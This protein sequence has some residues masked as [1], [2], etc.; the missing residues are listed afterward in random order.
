MLAFNTF[1]ISAGIGFVSEKR[2]ERRLTTILAADI[3]GYSRLMSSDEAGTLSKLKTH[4]KELLA[5][6]TTEYNGRVVKL[7]GD[8][9]LMEF[10]SVV[11]AINFAEDVQRSMK[12]RNE[13]VPEDHRIIYRIGV[14]IGDVIAEGDDLYGDG[15]NVASRL[16]ALAEPGGIC[17]SGNVFEH[18]KGKV[19][20]GFE[21]TGAQLVKNIPEP[22]Q[23]YR[24]MLESATAEVNASS[25]KAK[26]SLL[27]PA[28]A[29]SLLLLAV[30]VA[31][32]FSQSLREDPPSE[33]TT[34]TAVSDKPSIAVLPFNNL[35]DDQNQE[36]FVDGMTEDLITDLAKINNLFVIARNTSFTYKDKPVVV[37]EVA[38]ELGVKFV[39]EGSVRRIGDQVRINA[40]LIDGASG[41]HIWADR[42]DGNLA[43]VFALQDEVTGNIVEQLQ[44]TISPDE[45]SRRTKGDT[46]ST[47]AHD[48][49]LRGWQ[50]FRR[51]T[52]EDFVKAIPH[53]ERSVELDPSY[54]Q[55]WAALAALYWIA[56]RN[57]YAWSIIVNPDK[58]NG[59]SWYGALNKAE[60]NLRQAM[61][62]PTPLAHQIE[63]QISLEYRQYEQA[64]REAERAVGLNENDPAGHLAMAWAQIFSGQ[65]ESAITST[66]FG[67]QLDPQFPGSHLYA[68]GV[69][70]LILKRYEEAANT[71][72]RALSFNPENRAVLMPLSVAYTHLGRKEEAKVAL[73]GYDEFLLFFSPGIE[74]YLTRWPFRY[75]A[76]I[77]H[78]GEALIKAGLC[79]NT[80]LE[81]YL[82]KLRKGGTLE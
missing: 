77:R 6:K 79:C 70:Q 21:D 38:R 67:V 65:A 75:E 61:R 15:V 78:L 18:I 42:Y 11:D 2:I 3:V 82:E 64:L 8:G 14:N 10:G 69:A 12:E 55:A 56:Y 66:E 40:Q 34:L 51:N 59:V 45:Q 37:P 39:L 76:D 28:L 17:V 49:Y 52:P 33:A 62:N 50:F 36:Y 58:S 71:L 1:Y 25:G 41:A 31:A 30:L 19:D 35:S 54:G 73:E 80:D 60:A 63:S 4:R 27:W 9:T 72:E 43:D 47:A 26:R 7:M 81:T 22:I 46:E 44:I 20:I 68:R 5:P 23:T 29:G 24:V 74:T 16:E 32:L 13:S 53:L 48:A 57:G